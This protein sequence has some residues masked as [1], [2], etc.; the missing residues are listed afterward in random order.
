MLAGFGAFFTALTYAV[1]GYEMRKTGVKMTSE[2]FNSAGRNVGHRRRS[3]S[4]SVVRRLANV[5]RRVPAD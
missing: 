4:L 5:V 2:H 1:S 3:A